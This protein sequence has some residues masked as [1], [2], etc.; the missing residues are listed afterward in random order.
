MSTKIKR[1][2]TDQN[3]REMIETACYGGIT[4]WAVQ[5]TDAEFKA[6]PANTEW[7]IVDGDEGGEDRKAHYLTLADVRKAYKALLALDQ[8]FVNN[9]IH[10]YFIESWRNRDEDGIDGGF[11]DADAADVLVQVACFGEVVYG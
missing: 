5:P 8:P 7:C 3:I 10:G 2:L 4:Y 6:A 11:I 9:T 1:G